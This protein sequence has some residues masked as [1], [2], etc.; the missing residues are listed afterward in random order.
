M[1]PANYASFEEIGK[2]I[3]LSQKPV[4]ADLIVIPGAPIKELAEHGAY[5]WK[6]GYAPKILVSGKYYMTY[7][8]LEDE[9]NRFSASSGD[10]RS[11]K[12]EA[13]YLSRIMVEHGVEEDKIIQEKEATN[14][15]DNAKFSRKIIENDLKDVKHILL[16][17]QAFHARR[18]LMT[19][20]SELRDIEIT[21]CPV[22]TRNI[23]I[24]NWMDNLKSY[25]LVLSELRKCA[26]YFKDERM[27]ELR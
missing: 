4:R 1:K 7:E 9:F 19:F 10:C 23:D 21:V 18:A 5:L 14:T 3:F 11:C 16:C 25:N 22:V 27:Y 6:K 17:C 15:F 26:E 20:Q 8:S 13:E 2:F 24:N 12:T